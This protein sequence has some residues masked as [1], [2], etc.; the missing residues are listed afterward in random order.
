MKQSRK[1]RDIVVAAQH[2][3]ASVVAGTGRR[4][5]GALKSE[6][7]D[8]SIVYSISVSTSISPETRQLLLQRLT[9]GLRGVASNVD[10]ARV[11][12]F[13]VT[14]AILASNFSEEL[15]HWLTRA[16]EGSA[17]IYDKAMDSEYI[18]TGIG[19]SYH[20]LFDGGH[21]LWGAAK[22]GH[23]ASPDDSVVQE[24][25]GTLSALLKDV[26]TPRG[27]PLRTWDKDTFD[28]VATTLQDSLHIPKSWFYEIN[29]VNATELIS[30]CIV[31]V[32]LVYH[33]KRGDTKAFSELVGSS[34]LS[35]VVHANPVL[36]VLLIPA[37]A[38]SFMDARRTGQYGE[39]VEGLAKGGVGTGM[40]L[41]TSAIVPGPHV[42]GIVAGV[43]TTILVRKGM[44]NVPWPLVRSQVRDYMAD[45]FGRVLLTSASDSLRPRL[46]NDHSGRP[47]Q[48][49]GDRHP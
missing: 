44:E 43:C 19:G 34:G 49:V 14:Q 10:S 40:L 33:W 2:Q 17:S 21:T 11:Q 36:A 47:R 13:Q 24:T 48:V 20:R 32:G 26:V 22:A 41:A 25:I 46:H 23:H 39:F 37:L 45:S 12:A 5:S 7:T 30:S 29:T 18:Q 31:I 9:R 1:L 3:T 4:I 8:T 6:R 35:A 38:K 28:T 42:V 15:D 16:F 27:L